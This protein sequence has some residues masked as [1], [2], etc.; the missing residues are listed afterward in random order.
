MSQANAARSSH[1]SHV[2]FR[3]L[4]LNPGFAADL[5]LLAVTAG[6]VILDHDP[7]IGRHMVLVVRARKASSM[8][9]PGMTR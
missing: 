4:D 1:W 9:A 6:R 5:P 3:V 2:S 8:R 7:Y